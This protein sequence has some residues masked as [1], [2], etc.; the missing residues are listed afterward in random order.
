MRNKPPREVIG[1]IRMKKLNLQK[2]LAW[3][4]LVLGL[5]QIAIMLAAW[6]LTAAWPED[7]TRSLL[8]A[9]GI[10]WFF[11]KFQDNLASPILVWLVVLSIAY[12][13]Y[14]KS[15]IRAYDKREYRQR[16]AM[17]VAIFEVV[18]FVVAMLALTV[19]PHAI[20]LNVMGGLVPS[21]FSQSIIPYCAFAITVVCCSFGLISGSIKGVEGVFRVLTS[22]IESGAPFFVIY[23]F[24]AQLLCSI[25]YLI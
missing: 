17:S 7:F 4:A 15:R 14:R 1:M 24:A 18:I 9:E 2:I 21:S 3:V 22:G 10:R 13:S 5:G 8:S 25:L 20:L 23:V 19:L 11:G 16:F 12:G 6:L